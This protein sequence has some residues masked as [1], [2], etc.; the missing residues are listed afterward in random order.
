[1]KFKMV[2]CCDY[3]TDVFHTGYVDG[4]ITTEISKYIAAELKLSAIHKM[5]HFVFI[6]ISISG[7]CKDYIDDVKI[8]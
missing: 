5:S 4:G 1:M 8:Q 6:S 2:L 7:W 3:C